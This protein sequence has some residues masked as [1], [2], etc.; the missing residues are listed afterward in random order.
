MPTACAKSL[1]QV[2]Y[3]WL[4]FRIIGCHGIVACVVCVAFYLG[5]GAVVI[6]RDYRR[7]YTSARSRAQCD[8]PIVYYDLTEARRYYCKPFIEFVYQTLVL[9]LYVVDILMWP[10][11]YLFGDRSQTSGLVLVAASGSAAIFSSPCS[12][13]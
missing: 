8:D 11:F 2:C 13:P 7:E 5:V 6:I 3:Y 9:N 4:M 1:P 12:D 10:V